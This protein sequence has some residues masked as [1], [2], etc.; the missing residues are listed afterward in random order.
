[1]RLNLRDQPC[2]LKVS[3]AGAETI[4]M[5]PTRFPSLMYCLAA[6]LV[7]AAL[8]GMSRAASEWERIVGDRERSVEI[9]PASI[10]DS[11]N[12][13]KVAWGRVVLNNA[14]TGKNNYHTIKA[15][16]RYDCLNRNFVM[17]KRVYLD[18]NE[19]VVKEEAITGSTPTIVRR[20]SVDEQMWRAVCFAPS[21]SGKQSTSTPAPPAKRPAPAR[22]Q[23]GQIAAMAEQAAQ[24]AKP[25]ANPDAK[26]GKPVA[27][28][29]AP[30]PP[31]GEIAAEV[32][33]AVTPAVAS[34]VASSPPAAALSPGKPAPPTAQTSVTPAQAESMLAAMPMTPVDATPAATPMTPVTPARAR[35]APRLDPLPV[36]SSP[37]A[38]RRE[39]AGNRQPAPVVS[40]AP[41][42][43][44]TARAPAR[45]T[46][47]ARPVTVGDNDWRYSG[48]SGPERWG[49]L[50]PDWRLCSEGKRQSPID[51][52][53]SDPITVD[54]DPVIFDYGVSRVR[55][56]NTDNLLQA[57]VGEGMA[58]EVRGRKYALEGLT[59]HS[60]G[61]ARFN[62]ERAALEVHFFHRDNEGRQAIVAILARRGEE[63]NPLFQALLNN[64]PLEKNT[65]YAPAALIDFAAFLPANPGHF[66]YMGSLSAPPCTEETLWIVM[67]EPVTVSAA[68]L[69]IFTSL[70]PDNAR[71][72]QAANGRMVLESR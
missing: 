48:P 27:A 44:A 36:V 67:K 60:P 55:I 24:N 69:D 22:R 19:N 38:A 13:T 54:L 57:S 59:L 64:L 17:L 39:R 40:P 45:A 61:E 34:A 66:L 37:A 32:K 2:C 46:S 28:S 33:A 3:L 70:H 29:V 20:N 65:G 14:G 8:P 63:P 30:A 41:R 26:P 53:A 56:T 25:G 18:A 21:A 68:Q 11:D 6:V 23:I 7:A 52:A 31:R 35:P 62:G 47:A 50:R 43:Y 16:N 1:M 12:H 49:E 9:D 10:F 5:K 58:I 42:R 15:L 72:P 51:L 4:F 71:P